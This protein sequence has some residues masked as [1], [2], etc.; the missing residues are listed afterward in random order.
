MLES[1]TVAPT[2][3]IIMALVGLFTLVLPLGL[4]N[5]L[6]A[7]VKGAVAVFLHWLYHIPRLCADPGTD[8]TQPP[9][10]WRSWSSAAGKHL[11]V[12]FLCRSDGGRFEECGRWLAFKLSLRWSPGARGCADVRRGTWR[13]R[14]DS[15]GR[16][17]DVKQILRSLW[18]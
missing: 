5:F 16:D 14:G 6:L 8:C 17:D 15:A 4:W 13:H 18:L 10:L 7:K 1:L 2:A 3:I 12:C 9:A 11:A